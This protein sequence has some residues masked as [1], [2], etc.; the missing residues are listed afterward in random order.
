MRISDWSSDVCSSD[1]QAVVKLDEIE[2][3]IVEADFQFRYALKRARAA[4]L[5]QL[6]TGLL[7]EGNA[8]ALLDRVA[9][10]AAPSHQGYVI[11]FGGQR[12]AS[13]TCHQRRCGS[14]ARIGEERPSV[15]HEALP[16]KMPSVFQRF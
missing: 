10:E 1:L 7:R 11:R 2:D 15:D 4:I 12:H 13:G 16:V 9:P 3:L 5:D 14:P 8:D 6:D